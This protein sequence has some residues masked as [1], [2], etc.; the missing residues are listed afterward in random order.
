MNRIIVP[1]VVLLL[2]SFVSCATPKEKPAAKTAEISQEL[3]QER[4]AKKKNPLIYGQD[5]KDTWL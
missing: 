4:T 2:F 3:P 1:A 5:G